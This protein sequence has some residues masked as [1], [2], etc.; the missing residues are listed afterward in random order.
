MPIATL[1]QALQMKSRAAFTASLS[2]GKTPR[3]LA[4]NHAEVPCDSKLLTRT[5]PIKFTILRP[6]SAGFTTVPYKQGAKVEG[7]TKKISELIF[8]TAQNGA[9]QPAMKMWSFKKA[10]KTSDKGARNE[11]YWWTIEAGN[12]VNLWL[13]EERLNKAATDRAAGKATSRY[14]ESVVPEGIQTIP[15]FTVCEISINSRSEEFA[16]EGKGIKVGS[17]RPSAFGLHSCM[18]DLQFLKS[19]IAEAR[20]TELM[21]IDSSPPLHVDLETKDVPF[22]AWVN[23]NAVIDD[24]DLAETNAIKLLG[25]GDPKMPQIDIPVVSK[26]YTI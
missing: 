19:N 16:G 13:D 10:A 25:W 23:R 3:F 11:E 9:S 17:V 21:K 20:T 2:E 8:T 5:T 6:L 15:A 14:Y 12:T 22:W 24:A 7:A 4:I 1:D 18:G 26:S